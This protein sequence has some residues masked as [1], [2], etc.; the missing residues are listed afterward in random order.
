MEK[1]TIVISTSPIP[2][3]PETKYIDTI[4]NSIKENL[5]IDNEYKIIIACD[6]T[7]KVN[8]N[9]NNFIENL[10]NKFKTNKNISL[11]CNKERGHLTGN[12]KNAVQYV[13]TE[14]LMLVQHDLIFVSK[15]NPNKIIEDMINNPELKHLRFNKRDNLKQGW[16]NT[17]KFASKKIKGNYTYIMTESW[18]DQ[19]HICKTDYFKNIVLKNVKSKVFMET[20]LN[21]FAKGKHDIFGTF[22]IGDVGEKK[23]IVHLDGSETRTGS[24][25]ERYKV[26]REKYLS[27]KSNK[28]FCPECNFSSRKSRHIK[29]HKESHLKKN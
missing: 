3:N 21:D 7:D 22:I 25:R 17:E 15:I 9:Y 4:I 13:E 1:L 2:I 5:F 6:G 12:L 19:N 20:I 10:K 11:I 28:W 27:K 24:S 8:E 23:K 14:F 29:T 26:L 18:S 16:D